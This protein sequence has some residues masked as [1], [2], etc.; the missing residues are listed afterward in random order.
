MSTYTHRYIEVLHEMIDGCAWNIK[1]LPDPSQHE[2]EIYKISSYN[3]PE[4]V[5]PY[6]RAEAVCSD[7]KTT[8]YTWAPVYEVEKKWLPVKWYS[9]L[10]KNRVLD[11]RD[12]Y[13]KPKYVV[14]KDGNGKEFFL[15]EHILWA[16]NGGYIRDEYISSR[17]FDDSKFANRGLPNDVSE[18]VKKD[19]ESDYH[20]D[21]TY[22]TLQEWET[23]FEAARKDFEEK[24]KKRYMAKNLEEIKE[25][26]HTILKTIK[27]GEYKPKKKKKKD[28]E[29]IYY[30][31]T[32]EYLFE[33]EIWR[34]FLINEEIMK[35]EFIVD[36]FDDNFSHGGTRIIYYLA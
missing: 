21:M 13:Y 9:Y 34:L 25:S 33:D 8:A 22:V 32:I 11:N 3:R 7:G 29:D 19:I 31:D 16:N 5:A 26:I 28:D 24:V 30:E 4:D 23:A 12:P 10:P 2:G 20:Y 36:E 35:T 15:E 1:N 6:Y 18:E 14:A 27:D 17:G